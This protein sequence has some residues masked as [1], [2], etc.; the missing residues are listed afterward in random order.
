MKTC[1]QKAEGQPVDQPLTNIHFENLYR[2]RK[3]F[4]LTGGSDLQYNHNPKGYV[5]TFNKKAK[6]N[7][8]QR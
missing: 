1:L 7:L 8:S 3:K 5:S 6:C 4:V 2:T